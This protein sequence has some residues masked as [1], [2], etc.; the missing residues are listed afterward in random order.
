MITDSCVGGGGLAVA[1]VRAAG[2]APE[3]RRWVLQDIDP[4]AVAIAGVAMSVHG[5]PWVELSCTDALGTPQPQE[6][7]S[8]PELAIA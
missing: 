3:A 4:F 6:Q 7:F 5:I 8:Q 1:A 2:T